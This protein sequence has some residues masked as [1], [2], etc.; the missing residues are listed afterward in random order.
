MGTMTST[1]AIAANALSKTYVLPLA[2][3]RVEALRG[4][5]LEVPSG[6]VFGLLGPNGAGKTTFVKILLGMT[7]P[8]AGDAHMLGSPVGDFRARRHVGY[9]PEGGRFPGYHTGRSLLRMH[10][11]LAGLHGRALAARVDE[12]LDLVSMRPWQHMRLSR[13]SKGMVQRIGLAQALL[14]RPALLMLDEPTDG[15][16]PVGRAEVRELLDRLNS[17]GVTVFLNSHILAEVELFCRQV[18]ILVRGTLRLQGDIADLTRQAGYRLCWQVAPAAAGQA[19]GKDASATHTQDFPSLAEMNL[20][21]DRLRSHGAVI[22]RAGR[23]QAS[24][25][26]VF[27]KAVQ[28]TE[29]ADD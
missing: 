1:T 4:I 19:L 14:A 18:A 23:C 27:L 29:A 8:T 24:L 26:E 21:I 16:D 9:L 12:V 13:Y 7:R 10:G 6:S 3:R 20:A 28:Q 17:Q 11:Y 15:V 25:E 2:R 5:S 22:L